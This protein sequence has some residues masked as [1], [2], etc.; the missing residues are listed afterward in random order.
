[1]T[2]VLNVVCPDEYWTIDDLKHVFKVKG[3]DN[4]NPIVIAKFRFDDDKFRIYRGR[5]KLSLTEKGIRMSDDLTVKQMQQLKGLKEKG[6]IGYF[7]RGKLVIR[8]NQTTQET[9][10]QSCTF[11]EA[12]RRI[13]R[14]ADVTE[15]IDASEYRIRHGYRYRSNNSTTYKCSIGIRP[16]PIKTDDMEY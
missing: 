16:K 13:N 3:K 15:G 14:E 2:D 8:E 5:D 10:I 7:Y 12:T 1:M 11:R 9:S 4:D 6:Q